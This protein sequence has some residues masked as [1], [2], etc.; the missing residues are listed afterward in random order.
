MLQYFF[1]W[2]SVINTVCQNKESNLNGLKEVVVREFENIVGRTA[3]KATYSVKSVAMFALTIMHSP[4]HLL[5]NC[6][7]FRDP[8]T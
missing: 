7:S 5:R 3:R 6:S 8:I 4:F 1:L 2:G